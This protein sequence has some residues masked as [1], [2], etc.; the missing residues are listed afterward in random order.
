M[1]AHSNPMDRFGFLIGTWHLAYRL[2]EGTGTGTFEKALDSRYVFFN[3][4][5]TSPDGR[6]GGAHGIFAWDPDN[7]IYRYW[8]F[9][10]SGAYLQATCN[11]IN[12]NTLM[13]N[14]HD[15]LLIQTFR[16]TGPDSVVLE[17]K[18]PDQKGEYK[19][20]LLVELTRR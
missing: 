15:T 19:I 17:M 1:A 16:R 18:E 7:K 9:E 2:P 4:E 10:D 6:K 13:M 12:D 14:W 3:Y 8:W 20:V 11:F 5:A